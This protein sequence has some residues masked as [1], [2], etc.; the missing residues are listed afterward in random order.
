[1][2]PSPAAVG[3]VQRRQ[4]AGGAA[5]GDG[6]AG[7]DDDAASLGEVLGCLLDDTY[8]RLDAALDAAHQAAQELK[9]GGWA[10]PA[11]AGRQPRRTAAAAGGSAKVAGGGASAAAGGRIQ[12]HISGLA[13]PQDSFAD[14]I[15]NTNTPWSPARF[16]H[17]RARLVAAATAAS[18]KGGSGAADSDAGSSS[19]RNSRLMKL[20][21]HAE[22]QL[23]AAAA[24]AAAAAGGGGSTGDAAAV[25][26]YAAELEQL[27]YQPWQL[28]PAGGEPQAP[29]EFGATPFTLVDTPQGLSALV[30]ALQSGGV[31]Q[32]ALD[33]EH[34]SY[35][36]V[37]V[38]G[39]GE[40]C[41]SS[42][43]AAARQ[44]LGLLVPQTRPS[45][46]STLAAW[47]TT[48]PT[49]ARPHRSFQ[50]FTCLMQLSSRDADW[51]I[52]TLVLR[53]QLGPALSGL[54]AD[55]AVE[56]VLHGADSD[57]HWLQVWLWL[58][59]RATAG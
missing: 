9:L 19:L 7:D 57:I 21:A 4:G 37:C 11:A 36:C 45:C 34:H 47:R 31:T 40:G 13:R 25:H 12:R 23:A 49:H 38:G 53:D 58:W 30:A 18:G 10:A 15:D 6:D 33:L 50:G 3:A 1:V 32:I 44:R 8:E 2:R 54:L 48:R 28:Q 55:P 43:R 51:V 52:D 27:T 17:L 26:P 56:K 22:Q 24:A 20:Q 16:A 42:G 29:R 39:Q 14:T 5:D 35:R 59:L 46:V 41:C